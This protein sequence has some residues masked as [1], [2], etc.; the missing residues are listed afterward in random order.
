MKG[1]NCRCCFKNMLERLVDKHIEEIRRLHPEVFGPAGSVEE[2]K[3]LP[4]EVVVRSS[5]K[6]IV[7]RPPL[8]AS[9]IEL[10]RDRDETHL[11]VAH[12]TAKF[13]AH[14]TGFVD[15]VTESGLNLVA[16]L[17]ENSAFFI[18][19]IYHGIKHGWARGKISVA[20]TQA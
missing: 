7:I 13:L 3:V 20:K 11:R 16:E 18:S 12:K 2:G 1:V 10:S 15:G 6:P 9:R 8:G 4:Q 17:E 5:K 14:P 19:K